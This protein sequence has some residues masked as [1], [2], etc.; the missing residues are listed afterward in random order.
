MIG[1]FL[2]SCGRNLFSYTGY[3]SRYLHN[4]VAVMHQSVICFIVAYLPE[5]STS[6]YPL[7]ISFAQKI[8]IYMV[9]NFKTAVAL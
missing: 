2:Y 6:A 7:L 3:G 5:I 9:Y 4:I 1:L 8:F